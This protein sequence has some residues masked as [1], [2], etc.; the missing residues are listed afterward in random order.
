MTERLNGKLCL[1][2]GAAKGVGLAIA[3]AFARDGAIVVATDLR[4]AALQAAGLPERVRCEQLDVTDPA[5][6][7]LVVAS[8]GA[9]D[10][11]VNCVGYVPVGDAFS[12]TEDHLRRSFDLNVMSVFNLSQAV[13]PAMIASGG[14]HIINVAPAVS[15]TKADPNR[16]AYASSKAE[17]LAMTQG[18]ARDYVGHGIRCNS[19]SLGNVDT[20]LMQDRKFLGQDSVALSGQINS[21]QSIGPFGTTDEIAEVAVLLASGAAHFVNGADLEID[22]GALRCPTER[23]P[24]NRE[25]R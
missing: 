15:T 1:V 21:R 24:K 14:G 10:V 12:S 22:G 17:I 13:L 16:Y 11:L 8:T 25:I 5:A 9:L 18:I 19:I 6:A 2:T 23:I 7:K 4:L 3:R 20:L